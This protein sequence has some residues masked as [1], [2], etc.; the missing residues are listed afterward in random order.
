MSH[1]FFY[2]LL[3]LIGFSACQKDD[4]CSEATP[5]T[6]HLV[7]QFF[8][9]NNITEAKIAPNFNAYEV[10]DN[11][12]ISYYYE[13]AINDTIAKIPLRTDQNFTDYNLVIN[14]FINDGEIS[15]N[16]DQVSFT[17]GVND[18][19]VSRACGYKT[20]FLGLDAQVDQANPVENWIKTIEEQQ[21]N[22]VIDENT[23]HIYIYF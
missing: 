2:F 18:K 9:I 21:P 10:T 1:K 12:N 23:T 22:D 8:D 3:L 4:I 11:G 14:Q 13:T 17:Y 16:T 15:E 5:T 19:F 20:E 6:P 7:I